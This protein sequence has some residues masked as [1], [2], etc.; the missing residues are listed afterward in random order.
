MNTL[1]NIGEDKSRKKLK[2]PNDDSKQLFQN[3]EV[4]MGQLQQAFD[5]N[6]NLEV[7]SHGH[8]SDKNEPVQ[9]C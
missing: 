4:D 8:I 9:K 1:K 5:G 3:V 7:R 6:S 2:S